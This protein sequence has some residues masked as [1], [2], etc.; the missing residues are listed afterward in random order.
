MKKII[1]LIVLYL[2]SII[3]VHAQTALAKLKFE[4]A[5]QAFNN[6]DYKTALTNLKEA[7][8]LFGKTNP[9]IQHL[10]ILS[11]AKL[12]E[13][14]DIFFDTTT[15]QLFNTLYKSCQLFLQKN[16]DDER[17]IEKYKEVYKISEQIKSDYP[18]ERIQLINELK[19]RPTPPN[20]YKL[21]IIFSD[22][23]CNAI[24][25]Y[26]RALSIEK[27]YLPGKV[28]D[29][30]EDKDSAK[31]R[32]LLEQQYKP[33]MKLVSEGDIYATRI[34]ALIY[35]S[36]ST[37]TV[38][39]D[40]SANTIERQL[41]KAIAMNEK[42]A[43][44]GETNAMTSLAF[45]YKYG[46]KIAN[47]A[48]DTNKAL[49]WYAK[50]ME[51]GSISATAALG[52]WYERNKDYKK[53]LD[54]YQKGLSLG[55]SAHIYEC[56][57][58]LY[59]KGLGVKQDYAEA[60]K[61]YKLALGRGSV[62]AYSSI[63]TL[64]YGGPNLQQNLPVAM[65]WY[66]KGAEKFNPFAMSCIGWMYFKGQGVAAD[67]IE[68]EKW[69][70][71]AASAGRTFD[72]ITL[73]ENYAQLGYNSPDFYFCYKLD[74]SRYEKYKMPFTQNDSLAA[75]WF[76]KAAKKGDKNAAAQTGLYY[77]AGV[78]GV[79]EDEKTAMEYFKASGDTSAYTNACFIIGLSSRFNKT[80][81]RSIYFLT[82]AAERGH[83]WAMFNLAYR[84]KKGLVEYPKDK[85]KAKFWEQKYNAVK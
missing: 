80:L 56:L 11:Q 50:A 70:T 64:Y 30:R 85:D 2:L 71:K 6:G 10:Q 66:K 46:N 63:G 34:A 77:L 18:F 48:I 57:A 76:M 37:T 7:E 35:D 23:D 25:N 24:A 26:Y 29:L 75:S 27:G 3:P 84:Y 12:L 53:A 49:S 40:P 52:I 33:L 72:M 83:K 51:H 55:G 61:Y 68:A 67:I 21:F 22:L 17:L 60:L 14:K 16:V 58:E 45:L 4:D 78:N 74:K 32:I 59:E 15:L 62:V 65:E 41:K 36:D 47:I 31:A 42:A 82:Q 20:L 54:F 8:K 69:I 9:P 79:N 73:A 13:D 81:E 5:E 1:Y 28:I 44:G 38:A 43:A 39:F 19:Q